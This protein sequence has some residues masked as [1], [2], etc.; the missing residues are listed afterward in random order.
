MRSIYVPTV[1]KQVGR[2]LY[3][4]RKACVCVCVCGYVETSFYHLTLGERPMMER[5]SLDI[6]W[7]VRFYLYVSRHNIAHSI[8]TVHKNVWLDGVSGRYGYWNRPVWSNGLPD[9]AHWSLSS[10]Q[11][12][13]RKHRLKKRFIFYDFRLLASLV[14]SLSSCTRVYPTNELFL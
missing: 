9:K 11:H 10:P 14:H 1:S 6:W 13:E 2:S 8:D 3:A 7:S 5:T 12:L 4:G